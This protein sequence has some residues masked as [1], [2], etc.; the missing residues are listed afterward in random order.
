MNEIKYN[1]SVVGGGIVGLATAYKLQLNFPDFKI[2]VL[3]K[4]DELAIFKIFLFQQ[5]LEM[6]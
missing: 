3:E 5:Y 4:E 6:K 1:I 2:I